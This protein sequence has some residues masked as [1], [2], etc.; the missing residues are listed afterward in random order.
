MTQGECYP[1]RYLYRLR[2]TE[3]VCHKQ[4]AS[5][6]SYSQSIDALRL[7]ETAVEQ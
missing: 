5:L 4:I 6:I 7:L 2:F 3:R 1:L